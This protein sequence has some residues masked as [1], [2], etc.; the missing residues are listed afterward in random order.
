MNRINKLTDAEVEIL[1]IAQEEAAE[2]IQAIGKI[3]R[4]GFE[5]VSPET[6]VSNRDHLT[7]EV[8]DFGHAVARLIGMGHLS[9]E[10]IQQA[11]EDKARRIGKYLHYNQ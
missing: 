3:K 1:D 4:H 11:E 9:V 7:T 5:S 6:G 10:A 8:G 2:V